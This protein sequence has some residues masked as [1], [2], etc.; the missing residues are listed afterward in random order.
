MMANKPKL[1]PINIRQTQVVDEIKEEIRKGKTRIEAAYYVMGKAA[2]GLAEATKKIE[3]TIRKAKGYENLTEKQEDEINGLRHSIVDPETQ[4]IG[5]CKLLI[6]GWT[7]P[8]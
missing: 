8:D 2:K 7:K 3:A 6:A 5:H 4:R 1:R